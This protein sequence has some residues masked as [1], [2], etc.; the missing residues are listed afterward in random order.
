MLTTRQSE[1]RLA[2]ERAAITLARKLAR[3]CYHR[4]R[5]LGPEALAQADP[6]E[7]QAA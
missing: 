7:L 2:D 6:P 4:L 5:E 3:R 1:T